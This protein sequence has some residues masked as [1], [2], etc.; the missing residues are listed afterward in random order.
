MPEITLEHTTFQRLQ[1][2]AKPL[3]DTPDTV[4]NR[5]M[6]ALEKLE[7]PTALSARQNTSEREIDPRIIPNLTHTKVL[8]ASIDG[9]VI[10]KPNWNSLLDLILIRVMN[11][12]SDFNEVQKLCPVNMVKGRKEGEGYRHLPEIDISVQGLDANTA[13]RTVVGAAKG[14]GIE[15]D[16]GFLWRPNKK[17]AYPGERGRVRVPR[18]KSQAA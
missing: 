9:E 8:D 11:Q 16:I 1:Q 18:Q 7:E 3:V 10:Q 5:A 2:H 4:I 14:L 17:A 13:C 6:D 12:L 15:L